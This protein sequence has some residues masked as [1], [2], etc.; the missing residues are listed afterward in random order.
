MLRLRRIS[1]PASKSNAT[2]LAGNSAIFAM[3]MLPASL[4]AAPSTTQV[5][6]Q[7]SA[8]WS[9]LMLTPA[10]ACMAP[11]PS[12]ACGRPMQALALTRN[13][14]GAPENNASFVIK[15]LPQCT[16]AAK[17]MSI[18][19]LPPRCVQTLSWTHAWMSS[20]MDV[21]ESSASFAARMPPTSKGAVAST[22]QQVHPASARPVQSK[23]LCRENFEGAAF[24]SCVGPVGRCDSTNS[25]TR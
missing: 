5:H 3:R 13:A 21:R 15:K 25:L 14:L 11:R 10:P 4:S 22:R 6:G 20:A 9:S 23:P 12:P 2:A 18:P 8:R 24:L 16:G 19:R 1:R 7:R 17:T